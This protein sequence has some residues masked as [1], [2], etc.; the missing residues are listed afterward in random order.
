[1]MT[2]DMCVPLCL[3]LLLLC[4]VGIFTLLCVFLGTP[5]HIDDTAHL[6]VSA[7]IFFGECTV[8]HFSGGGGEYIARMCAKYE[9]KS[10]IVST[11]KT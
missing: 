2:I 10:E 9:K 3:R 6:L 4:S 8:R 5:R 1:M 11:H 7:C